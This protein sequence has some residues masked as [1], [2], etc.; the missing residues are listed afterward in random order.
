M[1]PYGACL[2]PMLNRQALK[3]SLYL[4]SNLFKN[5]RTADEW[6]PYLAEKQREVERMSREIAAAE[7]ELNE[8]VCSLFHLLP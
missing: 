3:T 5:P 6:E 2:Q 1:C 4:Q 8:R 7:A